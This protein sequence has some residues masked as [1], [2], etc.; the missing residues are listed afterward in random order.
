[1]GWQDLKSQSTNAYKLAC[2]IR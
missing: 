1:M 2:V